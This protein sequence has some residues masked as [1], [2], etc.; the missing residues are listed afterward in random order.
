MKETRCCER[1]EG[2]EEESE[3]D[4]IHW[5]RSKVLVTLTPLDSRAEI[6]R[7]RGFKVWIWNRIGRSYGEL[8]G[9]VPIG[10]EK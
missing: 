4:G 7:I 8:D 3:G 2:G 5:R 1:E 6:L 9:Q 10:G